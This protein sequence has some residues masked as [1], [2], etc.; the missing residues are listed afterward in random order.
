MGP[1]EVLA[2]FSKQENLPEDVVTNRKRN[3]R[4]TQIMPIPAPY[5]K[6]TLTPREW[7]IARLISSGLTNNEIAPLAGTT[8]NVVKNYLRVIYDKT[9]LST[10]LEVALW[11]IGITEERGMDREAYNASITHSKKRA[12]AAGAS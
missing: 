6:R 7:K 5:G 1:L 3:P 2:A 11:F 9:G 8:E 4:A 12:G 10:R